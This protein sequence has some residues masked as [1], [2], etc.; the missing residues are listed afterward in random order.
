MELLEQQLPIRRLPVGCFGEP[1]VF[2]VDR[3]DLA[4]DDACEVVA[5]SRRRCFYV[6]GGARGKKEENT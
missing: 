3:V 5:G 6:Y 2:G 1:L 4:S